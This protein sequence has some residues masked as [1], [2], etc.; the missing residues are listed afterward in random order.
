MDTITGEFMYDEHYDV[1]MTV[2]DGELD[3]WEVYSWRD[4]DH[5]YNLSK[6]L[7]DQLWYKIDAEAEI[8]T[9]TLW[10]DHK[11]GIV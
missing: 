7:D 5:E 10:R 9:R 6:D 8:E 1:V 11:E 3:S 2:V 4:G